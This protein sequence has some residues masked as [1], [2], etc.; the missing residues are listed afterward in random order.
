MPVYEN[1]V[2]RVGKN[3]R[4]GFRLTILAMALAAF[5]LPQSERSSVAQRFTTAHNAVRAKVGVGP[6]AWSED[7]A[8]L[9]QA[10]A[11]RLIANGQ[12][13]HS[14]NPK[15]GENLYEMTGGSASP[16]IVV[17]SW[18]SEANDYSYTSNTCR[19]VCGHYTQIVW[20]DTKAVGCAVAQKGQR[21]VW[22]CE[23]G[24]PGNYVGR[25]PY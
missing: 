6:L 14:H 15:T 17:N 1:S 2:R 23:Y 9:A 11:N 22:V 4:H 10:W 12:F 7:L 25:K 13:D 20:A 5:A 16:E 8:K 21:E 3:M 19:G 18:A 24:P